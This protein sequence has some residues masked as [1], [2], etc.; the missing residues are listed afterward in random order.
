MAIFVTPSF[1]ATPLEKLRPCQVLPPTPPRG[2][3]GGG[4]GGSAHYMFLLYSTL[5]LFII[6]LT[7][8]F[9][10]FMKI[11]YIYTYFLSDNVLSIFYE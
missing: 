1:P 5:L 2:G 8:W 9:F 11:Q 6:C 3:G 10:V 4:G 7:K